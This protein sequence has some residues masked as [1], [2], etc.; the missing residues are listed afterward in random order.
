MYLCVVF[1]PE[2]TDPVSEHIDS[3]ALLYMLQKCCDF[4][5]GCTDEL[6]HRSS[7]DEVVAVCGEIFDVAGQGAGVAGNVDDAL[8]GCFDD[9]V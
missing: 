1:R 9:S 4:N 7:F 2:E 8:R 5:A 6:I 3:T